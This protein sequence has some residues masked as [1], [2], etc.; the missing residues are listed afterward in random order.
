MYTSGLLWNKPSP[1]I[2]LFFYCLPWLRV[3]LHP[4]CGTWYL[5]LRRARWCKQRK[6]YA[7]CV[8]KSFLPSSSSLECERL[9]FSTMD[10]DIHQRRADVVAE[11]WAVDHIPSPHWADSSFW[12][13]SWYGRQNYDRLHIHQASCDPSVHSRHG[14]ARRAT[15]SR[16][17]LF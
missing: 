17:E 8:I 10:R 11:P 15:L 5:Q 7:L 9:A 13:P 16:K 2:F 6:G 14:L 1:V 12:R 3:I 4:A